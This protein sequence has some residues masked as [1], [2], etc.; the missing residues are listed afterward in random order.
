VVDKLIGDPESLAEQHKTERLEVT[1]LFSD[2]RGFTAMSERLEP[3]VVAEMVS[4]H[5]EAMAEVVFAH[6]GIVD[7]YIG[8]SVMAVFG[9]PFP[10][11]DHPQQ[12]V[13][14]GLAMIE[15]QRELQA[16]WGDRVM[17]P[18]AIGVG[19][20]TG[21]AIVGDVGV[22][23][24]EFTHLGDSVNL[25]SRLKDVAAPWQVLA[26]EATYER[27]A[28]HVTGNQ[29]PP[30]TVKGKA[31]PVIAYEITAAAAV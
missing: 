15:R 13:A 21:V 26:S 18:L 1:V 11:A 8:D 31:A 24:R 25:A 3:D 9:S 16:Q 4:E 10:Q 5:L 2:I 23:R 17:G 22:S 7:K 30:I 29:L 19:I 12:A 6:D 28:G 20:N 27:A 14:C